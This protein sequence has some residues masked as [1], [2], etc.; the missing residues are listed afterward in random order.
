MEQLASCGFWN[1]F[2][3]AIVQIGIFLISTLVL[4]CYKKRKREDVLP[5]DHIFAEE[6]FSK[7]LR[8]N[9][10]VLSEIFL[11]VHNSKLSVSV[12]HYFMF[13]L[14]VCDP[15]KKLKVHH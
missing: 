2:L 12:S 15:T 6:A 7:Y 10:C 14:L 13:V 4:V 3:L 5:N 11:L 8:S 1:V 9:S